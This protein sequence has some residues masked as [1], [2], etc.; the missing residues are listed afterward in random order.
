MEASVDYTSGVSHRS[1]ITLSDLYQEHAS[2]IY[3]LGLRMCPSKEAAEDLVQETFLR[4]HRSWS[5][6]EGRSKPSTWLWSI[7]VR[8]CQRMKRK[9]AGEPEHLASWEELLPRPDAPIAAIPSI[10]TDPLDD[11]IREEARA[12]VELAIAKLPEA[13]RISLVL[14]DIAGLSQADIAEILD[15]KEATVKTRVHRARL[16]VRDAVAKNFPSRH[17]EAEQVNPHLCLDLLHAKMESLDKGVPFAMPDDDLCD[18]CRSMFAGLDLAKDACV[19]IRAGQLPE[20]LASRLKA[21]LSSS[22]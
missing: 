9:R 7:A 21:H 20:P 22:A 16:L 12:T 17:V 5:T 14:S 15:V 10:N 19:N 6:F 3:S 8:A 2:T 4:A 11:I 13:F 1:D 18:R